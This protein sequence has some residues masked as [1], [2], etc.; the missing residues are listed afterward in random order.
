METLCIICDFIIGKNTEIVGI[1]VILP[2]VF[3]CITSH[4][5]LSGYHRRYIF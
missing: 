2:L 1:T 4:H 3:K 5:M